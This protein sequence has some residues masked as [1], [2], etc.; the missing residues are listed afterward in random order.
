MSYVTNVILHTSLM[1]WGG[2][3]SHSLLPRVNA[4]FEES[5]GGG[6]VAVDDPAL[7]TGWYGGNKFLEAQ[8]YLGAFNYLILEEFIAHLRSLP[9]E[10]PESVQLIIKE[11]NDD[12][13]RVIDLFD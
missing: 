9:W 5:G 1:E 12:K 6:L 10:A 8:L 7:P 2:W 4:F 13:F 11:E 3:S